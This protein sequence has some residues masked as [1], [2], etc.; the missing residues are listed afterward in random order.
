VRFEIEWVYLPFLLIWEIFALLEEAGKFSSIRPGPD[1][2]LEYWRDFRSLPY[3]AS[4]SI[5]GVPEEELSSISPLHVHI[6]G[7][8][9]FKSSGHNVE[10]LIYSFSG[11][12]IKGPSLKTKFIFGQ[13]AVWNMSSET[14]S[15]IVA[16]L[17]WQL[18]TA[19]RGVVPRRGYYNETL[20]PLDQQ[21]KQF[22]RAMF[23]AI[24]TDAKEKVHQ[25]KRPRLFSFGS[26]AARALLDSLY[27]FSSVSGRRLVRVC[28]DSS[29]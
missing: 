1:L 23:T 21:P 17:I 13:V 6:D 3:T 7:V 4:H 15:F 14:N 26:C 20:V 18:R 22:P 28:T 16:F 25:H 9:V 11:A 10:N 19:R 24:K 8:K 2:T 29:V 27:C 12:L 5:H